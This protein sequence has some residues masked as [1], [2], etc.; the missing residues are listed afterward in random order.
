MLPDKVVKENNELRGSNS[1]LKRLLYQWKKSPQP[2][3]ECLP[4][5][6]ATDLSTQWHWPFHLSLRAPTLLSPPPETAATKD[7]AHF[8][9]D[10]SFLSHL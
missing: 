7:N 6:Q 1:Q 2:P 3:Q 9:Q 10:S 5:S 8:P 4:T